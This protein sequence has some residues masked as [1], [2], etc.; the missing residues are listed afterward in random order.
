MTS[1]VLLLALG[2]DS[3]TYEL[4]KYGQAQKVVKQT[5]K[6]I[7]QIA[8]QKLRQKYSAP[9]AQCSPNRQAQIHRLDFQ[10]PI[11]NNC[12]SQAEQYELQV[13]QKMRDLQKKGAQQ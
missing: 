12:N 2:A 4:D 13:M 8:A 9:T 6:E 10:C 3:F 5:Q 1:L 7:R 11:Q